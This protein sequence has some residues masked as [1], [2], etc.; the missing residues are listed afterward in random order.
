MHPGPV[1]ASGADVVADQL[2]RE[3]DQDRRQGG[4]PWPLRDVPSGRGRS[5]AADV[6]GY[7][8]ADCPAAGAV[9][10]GM[11][12]RRDRM[13][14]MTRAEVRLDHGKPAGCSASARSIGCLGRIRRRPRAIAVAEKPQKRPIMASTP[15]QSGECRLKWIARSPRAFVCLMC[16]RRTQ[17]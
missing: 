7:P 4:Q 5:S 3:A 11:K 1:G 6:R 12:G 15:R 2:A 8:D 13:R 16:W 17:K 14:Q 9:R 10:T